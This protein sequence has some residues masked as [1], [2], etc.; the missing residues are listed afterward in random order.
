VPRSINRCPQCREPV[1]PFA[2]GCAICGADLVAARAA[3][4]QRRQRFD[5]L[6]VPGL[7]RI[8]L[9]E[10]GLPFLIGLVLALGAPVIGFVLGAFVAWQADSE[11][12][13]RRRNLMLVVVLIAA[14]PLFTGYSLFGRFLAGV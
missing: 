10:D 3:L 14:I 6:R 2:A 9:G 7:Q 1:T 4:A 8:G 12:R 13:T 11:G 5:R